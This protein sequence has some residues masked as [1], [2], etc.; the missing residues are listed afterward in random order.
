MRRV[1]PVEGT[2]MLEN[3]RM[4]TLKGWTWAAIVGYRE[5]SAESNGRFQTMTVSNTPP[6]LPPK[7]E[8][9]NGRHAPA[10]LSFDGDEVVVMPKDYDLFFLCA[11]KA[12]ELYRKPIGR[13]ERISRFASDLLVPLREWCLVRKDLIESCHL[14][15]PG[16][17]IQVF[18]V[19][20]SRK[21]DFDLADE[22]AAL[23]LG[24]ARAGWRIGVMQLPAAPPESLA[25]FFDADGALQVY[26]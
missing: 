6:L 17:H 12:T 20:K 8:N 2:E 9:Q 24:L 23:E 4:M 11:E 22:M 26:A 18:I 16:I 15:I 25:A 7:V 3:P 13:D 19:T 5:A 10:R 1:F 21:F 14:P